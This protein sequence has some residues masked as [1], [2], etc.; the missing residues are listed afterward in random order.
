MIVS[1]T[2]NLLGRT[3]DSKD[4]QDSARCWFRIFQVT[5]KIRILNKITIYI[6]VL[7]FPRDNIVG[8]HLYDE[9]KR[10]NA[11]SVCHKILSIW[12]FARA[13]LF[14]DHKIS[15]LPIRSKYKHFRTI[16]AHTFDNSPIDFVSSSLK[17]WSSMHGV[18]TLNNC[19]VVL[20]ASS[21]YLSTHFFAWPSISQ[22]HE[23]MSA[24]G[25]FHWT[26]LL[27]FCSHRDPGFKHISVIVHN[28]FAC[29][30]FPLSTTQINE[31]KKW[32]R[33]S[34]ISVFSE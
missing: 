16:W 8:F 25:G 9:W 7:R 2:S 34:Q 29:F 31:V 22:D 17:W 30:A 18:A 11:P 27:F 19:W 33:F 12:F 23:E 10:S 15:G 14:T 13:S 26:K 4:A 6:V 28:I 32:C 20:F 5:G 24:S 1:C 21:Q 3:N